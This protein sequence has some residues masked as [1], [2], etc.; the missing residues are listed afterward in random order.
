M[1]YQTP[2]W[3]L[4]GI[5]VIKD[6]GNIRVRIST[7][8]GLPKIGLELRP[9]LKVDADEKGTSDVLEGMLKQ[10]EAPLGYEDVSRLININ[11]YAAELA[12]EV[13][14]VFDTGLSGGTQGDMRLLPGLKGVIEKGLIEYAS[15][16]RD[17]AKPL[18]RNDPAV[19]KG[20]FLGRSL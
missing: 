10:K 3:K 13:F 9:D 15:K 6:Y 4:K 1:A 5:T 14:T 2:E 20:H 18:F 11:D 17:I 7:E 12:E 16:V 8:N 19:T